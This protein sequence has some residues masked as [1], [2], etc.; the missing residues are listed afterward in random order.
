MLVDTLDS[1]KHINNITFFFIG[2]KIVFFLKMPGLE[3]K[4]PKSTKRQVAA[5]VSI[6]GLINGTYVKAEGWLPN[7][8]RLEDGKQ[9]SRVNIIGTIVFKSNEESGN[10]QNSIIDDGSAKI[11]LRSFEEDQLNKFD[12][13]DAILVIGRPR[14]FNNE[15]YIIP[16]ILKKIQNQT[17]MQVRRLELDNNI[18]KNVKIETINNDEKEN[19]S[20]NDIDDKKIEDVPTLDL[21]II[22]ELIKKLDSGNGVSVEKVIKNSNNKDIENKVNKLLE[23]GDIF[24]LKPGVLKVLE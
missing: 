3:Q 18:N 8:V 23:N 14:E 11:S 22:Y 9:I 10:Y 7:F 12:I 1:K 16:E 6:N 5:K 20:T 19:V 2:G 4:Q 21:D 24:E 15:M 13:G 17:W